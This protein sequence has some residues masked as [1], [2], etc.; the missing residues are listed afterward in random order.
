MC[1]AG[2]SDTK[3]YWLLFP[4][5]PNEVVWGCCKS[6]IGNYLSFAFINHSIMRDEFFSIPYLHFC[7]YFFNWYQALISQDELSFC[8]AGKL[9]LLPFLPEVSIF[10]MLHNI[11]MEHLRG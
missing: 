9:R 5:D 8:N 1:A 4:F 6:F 3:L 10:T 7:G 11:A 2:G